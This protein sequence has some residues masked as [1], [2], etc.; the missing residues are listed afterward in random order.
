LIEDAKAIEEA[1]ASILLVEAVPPETGKAITQALSIPVYGIAYCDGQLLI[2]SNML[3]IFE[4]FTPKFVKKYAN[5]AGVI[6][7]AF[8]E[9]A[10]DIREGNFP[11]DDHCYRMKAG[12]AEK[13]ATMLGQ[14]L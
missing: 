12:E 8:E 1:G 4:V 9:Y 11:T 10:R 5:L 2:V 14:S 7:Q 3:G 6:K 13:L